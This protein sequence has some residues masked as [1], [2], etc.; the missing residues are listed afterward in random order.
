MVTMKDI[1]REAGVSRGT[2]DRV[3]HNR[4]KVAPEKA[5]RI[6]EIAEKMGYQPNLAGRG[7]AARKKQLKIGFIYI[8]AAE[9]PF[10]KAIYKAAA[11]CAQELNQYGVDVR[12]FPVTMEANM[13]KG[14]KF[15]LDGVIGEERMD[16][17]AVVGLMAGALVEVL[18]ER[19]EA[20]VPIVSYNMDEPCEWKL[21]YVGCD[22]RQSGRLACGVAALMTQGRARV[23]MVSLDEG[24]VPSSVERIQGFEEEMEKRYPEMSIGKKVFLGVRQLD[25]HLTEELDRYLEKQMDNDVLYLV[26][27]GDYSICKKISD[28]NIK[29]KVRIITNDL[30]TEEQFKMVE[31]GDISVTI[32][33]EPEKQGRRSLEIL[34]EYLALNKKQDSSWCKA[35]LSIHIAQNL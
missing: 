16:G 10:H 12:F 11:K 21:A 8:D 33:Q 31:K 23:C 13:E 22:Y 19:G 28:A 5:K 7:L 27:P 32:C 3:L 17:W 26:N 30:V 24:N 35:E 14:W 34:F 18:K 29:H 9:A 6:R 2:V 25:H 20:Y 1:A 4:G 15:I